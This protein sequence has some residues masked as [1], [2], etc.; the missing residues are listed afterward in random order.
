MLRELL[1]YRFSFLFLLV[2]GLTPFSSQSQT[3]TVSGTVYDSELGETI[4]FSTVKFKGTT[5]STTTDLDGNYT[6]TT[7]TPTDSLIAVSF[8]FED[9]AKAVKKGQTQIIDFKMGEV[10]TALEVVEIEIPENPAH[11]IVRKVIA[12]KEKTDVKQLDAY[13]SEVYSKVELDIDNI[14]EKFKQKKFMK[15]IGESFDNMGMVKDEDG[16]EVLPIFISETMSDYYYKKDPENQLEKVKATRVTGIGIDDGSFVSQLVGST[17]QQ[18]NFYQNSVKILEKDFVSP[19]SAGWK[20]TYKYIL[21]DTVLVDGFPCYEIEVYPKR[22][23]DLGFTGRMWMDYHNYALKKVD[24][25]IPK[26]ANLNFIDEI[27][28]RQEWLPVGNDAWYVSK[29]RLTIDVGDLADN[30]ASMILKS[31]ITNDN[32]KPTEAKENKFYEYQIE[33][34]EDAQNKAA[35]YWDVNRPYKLSSEEQQSFDM[36]DS[37]RNMPSVKTY[38]DILFTIVN[39]YKTTGWF[40]WGP[41]LYLYSWN[42]VEGHKVRIGGRTNADFHK[43]LILEGYVAPSTKDRKIK[44]EAGVHYI[45][46][47]TPWTQ[48]GANRRY[49]LDQLGV[50]NDLGGN[51]YQSFVRWGNIVGA[52]Y[53]TE[54]NLYL[55]RQLNKNFQGKVN[56][57]TT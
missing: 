39:G 13:E 55:F 17:F 26:E 19:F 49:D 51:L 6:I 32:I 35:D 12:N 8:G 36:V 9:L 53:T 21:E 15:S 44:Y 40:D 11:S 31:T 16:K 18:F 34:A 30:W 14:S 5:I 25:T 2:L 41:Y 28:L 57:D 48:I 4:P 27:K 10:L 50:P 20:G 38:I 22:A 23:Q 42:D 45:L 56:G 52:H 3:T 33:V 29:S 24:F 1:N 46:D 7:S 54:N 47:R 43:K 37:L